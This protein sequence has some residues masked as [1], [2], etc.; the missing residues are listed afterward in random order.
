MNWWRRANSYDWAIPANL[1][2]ASDYSLALGNAPD[3]AYSGEFAITS[4]G[5]QAAQ[6]PS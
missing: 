1:P 2:P 4:P 5:R 3:T 6:A